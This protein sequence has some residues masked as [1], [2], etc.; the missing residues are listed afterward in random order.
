[1]G[2][3]TYTEALF[4]ASAAAYAA[5]LVL[6]LVRQGT[7][8]DL[9]IASVLQLVAGSA[10]PSRISIPNHG[11]RRSSP[12]REVGALLSPAYAQTTAEPHRGFRCSQGIASR[13]SNV[14]WAFQ[15]DPCAIRFLARPCRWR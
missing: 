10:V 13:F 15:P 8:G 2:I 14:G 7:D 1:M 12:V 9:L 5:L 11:A 4:A 6:L 3:A